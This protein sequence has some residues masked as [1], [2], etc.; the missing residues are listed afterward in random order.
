MGKWF[1]TIHP[2]LKVACKG[3]EGN[4]ARGVVE[5][6]ARCRPQSPPR[7]PKK[8]NKTRHTCGW[9]RCLRG[10]R[11]LIPSGVDTSH[12]LDAGST[13]RG[14]T[15]YPGTLLQPPPRPDESET[16]RGRA[17]VT[18]RFGHTLEI[19]AKRQN[20]RNADTRVHSGCLFSPP[21]TLS[22]QRGNFGS[23]LG[24]GFHHPGHLGGMF[25]SGFPLF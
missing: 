1:E 18:Q 9:L 17:G 15:L 20:Y 5:G 4:Q 24:C 2:C 3:L 10:S 6:K 11:L 8:Q 19:T 21:P 16:E 14:N 7:P 23:P 22:W 13:P 25:Y 12:D